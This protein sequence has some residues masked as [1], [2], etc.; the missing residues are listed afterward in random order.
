MRLHFLRS[1]TFI[2]ICASLFAWSAT[3]VS[4]NSTTRA[5]QNR[6]IAIA[7]GNVI[8]VEKIKLESNAG[9]GAALGGLIGLA[10]SSGRSNRTKAART[11][12][13]AAAGGLTKRA[14]EGSNQAY[15]YTVRLTSG[16]TVK[17]ITDQTGM[18]L[19]DC[20]SVEQGARGNI[21]RVSN[22]HCEYEDSKPTA[23]HIQ[24]ADACAQ[25]KEGILAATTDEDLD[26]AIKRTRILCED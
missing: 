19:N 23:D 15:E 24:E 18:R 4:E 9:K 13:G 8:G 16:Q 3:A 1:I 12:V 7:Y 11:A 22:V 26:L 6:V 14:T 17:M 20:V 21:R 25:A 10:S 2:S 5:N